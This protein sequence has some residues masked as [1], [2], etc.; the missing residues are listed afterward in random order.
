MLP[1]QDLEA[2][3]MKRKHMN[4]IQDIIRRLQLGESERRIA[5]DMQ[6]S[7]QTVHKYHEIAKEQGYLETG[8]EQ[9]SE[10]ELLKSLGPGVQAP[11]QVSTVEPHREAIQ[12][13]LNQGVEMTAIWLRLRENYGYQGGYSSIRRYVCRM[14]GVEPEAFIRVHSEPG[15]D[16]QVDFGSVGQLYDPVSQRMR[17]A[18]V[19]VATLGYSRHQ[20]A[21]L[22]FDQKVA[23]WIALH[24]RAFEYFGGV[25]QRVIPDNLKAAV[26]KA[27]VHDPI[28]GEAYRRMALHYGFLVSPTIPHT[29][30]HKGKVESGVHYVKRN[31]MAGQEF[32]DINVGNVHLREWIVNTAGVRK[33]GTTGESPLHLFHEIEQARLQPLPAEPFRLLE[34]RPV[35]VH[36]DCHVVILGSFYSVPFGYIGQELTAHVSGNFVEIYKGQELVAT[37]PHSTRP[38]Q[39][40]TRLEDYPPAKAAYL[41][42]TPDYCKKLGA[43]IGPSTQGVVEQLLADRP[44]DRLRSVQAIL[45]LEQSV[46]SKRLEAACARAVYFG[47]VRYRQIKNILNAALDREPLPENQPAQPALSHVFARSGEEFFGRCA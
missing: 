7:R 10:A 47:D 26:L 16:M 34:I 18:Y 29:P 31:F 44:L 25:P 40:H 5:R 19:F 28:L 15:E 30:R 46:G 42:H 2:S 27:L 24:K 13:W 6:I 22:V 4:H 32:V 20:Y 39:W 3:Y 8:R 41:I 43:K 9:P 33:H 21:E 38:G 23:T 37:H 17:T 35:K 45:K 14:K 11:K 1:D 36:P 12:A